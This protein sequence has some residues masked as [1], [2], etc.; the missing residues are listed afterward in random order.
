MPNLTI[1]PADIIRGTSGQEIVESGIAGAT[2]TAGQVIYRDPSDSKWKLAQCDG[3]TLEAGVATTV[4]ISLHAALANQPISFIRAGEL[5]FGAILSIGTIYVISATA[6]AIA[7]LADLTTDD[8]I[9]LIG[10]GVSD[11]TMKL[12]N[13]SLEVQVPAP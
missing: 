10:V 8:Y 13:L 2:I 1:T 11:S 12:I 9:H 7:E 4:A 3:T 5:D 6:G